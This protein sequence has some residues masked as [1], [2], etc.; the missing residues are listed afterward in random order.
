M[1]DAGAHDIDT[2]T[3][4]AIS[5]SEQ[6]AARRSETTAFD[7]S[8]E[9]LLLTGSQSFDGLREAR[10]VLIS[11]VPECFRNGPGGSTTD[12][13]DP[14]FAFFDS[15]LAPRFKSGVVRVNRAKS[16]QLIFVEFAARAL[17]SIVVRD[18]N[19]VLPLAPG[20]SPPRDD[21]LAGLKIELSKGAEPSPPPEDDVR[22]SA[23]D[24]GIDL[25]GL[26]FAQGGSAAKRARPA[27]PP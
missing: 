24:R 21:A 11:N 27:T 19:R 6:V 18:L 3:D 7:F 12:S 15:C 10:R 8:G 1:G 2:E 5:M 9:R 16:G 13:S 22:V 20:V 4:A 17:A 26:T 25:R 23:T 14:V